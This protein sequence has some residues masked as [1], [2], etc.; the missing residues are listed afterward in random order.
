MHASS[1][2]YGNDVPTEAK[3]T[4]ERNMAV[5]VNYLE[6]E[7]RELVHQVN[8]LKADVSALQNDLS[9][10]RAANREREQLLLKRESDLQI[11]QQKLGDER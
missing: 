3:P 10:E 7:N 2:E 5:E 6:T 4:V 11:L 8:L 1:S 9:K